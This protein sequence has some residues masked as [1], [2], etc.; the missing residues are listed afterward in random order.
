MKTIAIFQGYFLPHTGGVER[1]TYNLAKKL[2][3]KGYK[4]IIVTTR[5]K[6]ELSSK[7]NLEYATIY[8]LPIYKIFSTRYPIIK[9]DKDYRKIIEELKKEN[10]DSIILNTR[11]QL[12]TLIGAKFAKKNK[13]PCC[14]IEHGSS[15][16]TVYNK[17]LD[18]F[19]HI[20]EH[21]LT[22]RVKSLVKDFYG[23]SKACNKWLE[24]FK[25]KA[26]S[27]FYNAIDNEEY[28][29]YSDNKAIKDNEIIKILF[30]GRLIKEKGIL[31][32]IEAFNELSEKYNN[33]ELLI[34]G[35]GP[36]KD[37]IVESKKIKLTGYMGHE[38]LMRLYN[39]VDIFVSPS[40]FAE[41][42][43]TTI[44]EAGLMKCAVI[45]TPNA[46]TVEV[47]EDQNSGL[48]C[49]A[50]TDSIKEKIELLINNKELRETIRE[51]IH[52]KVLEKFTWDIVSQKIIDEIK[53]K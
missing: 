47:I 39:K 34:A 3:S 19:G 29:L 9:K 38:E 35:D 52:N 21:L 5:H 46:G 15:H 23:V 51:N 31:L 1:Y 18:F 42:L 4:I 41:G 28:N 43:P 20:Y 8:R 2:S 40:S 36:L 13:I 30:A 16:F 10:I 7:E 17:I 11:F 27:I 53:Y 32:L 50:T 22:N 33:I 24:H 45:A 44:L 25:I 6:T 12:T 26:N 37:K 49:D 48:L 14:V